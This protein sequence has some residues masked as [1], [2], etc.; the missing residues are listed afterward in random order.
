M[1]VGVEEIV[2]FQR[3]IGVDIATML[4]VFAHSDMKYSEVEDAVEETINRSQVSLEAAQ[5]VM[6]NGPIQ[7]GLHPELR[8]KSAIGMSEFDFSVHLIGGI[9]PVMEQQRYR[10]YAKIMLSSIPFL[11]SN[12]PIHVWLWTSDVVSNVDCFRR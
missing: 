9:V 10:D 7:G 6:L 4:D 11:P 1:E 8:Q 5:S 3:S 2:A 12:K